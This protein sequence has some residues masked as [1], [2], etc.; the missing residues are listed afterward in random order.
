VARIEDERIFTPDAPPPPLAKPGFEKDT[1]L[2]RRG[3]IY[4]TRNEEELE[5]EAGAYGQALL[6]EPVND[7]A[8]SRWEI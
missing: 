6:G 5:D 1:R 4:D 3:Q 8:R 7:P 2:L